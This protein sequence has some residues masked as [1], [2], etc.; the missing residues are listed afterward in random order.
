[1]RGSGGDSKWKKREHHS[2]VWASIRADNSIQTYTNGKS[3]TAIYSSDF[4]LDGE[5]AEHLAAFSGMYILDCVG[6][7][8]PGE[9]EAGMFEYRT[10]WR[11][12][13]RWSCI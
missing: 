5:G 12:W 11:P 2:I 7:E 13:L 3:T 6:P 8:Q 4:K 10:G 1:M 9:G